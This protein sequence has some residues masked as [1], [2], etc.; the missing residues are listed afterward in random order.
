MRGH[1]DMTA[2]FTVSPP[3]RR[4]RGERATTQFRFIRAPFG[5]GSDDSLLGVLAGEY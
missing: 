3:G 4:T 2:P 5:Y 1:D